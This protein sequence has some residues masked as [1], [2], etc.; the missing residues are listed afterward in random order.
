[1]YNILKYL[2][3]VAMVNS[4][5]DAILGKDFLLRLHDLTHD[6]LDKVMF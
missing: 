3:L 6:E 1:M 2:F 4:K 5:D